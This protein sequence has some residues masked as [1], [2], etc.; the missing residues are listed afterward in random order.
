MHKNV[1][2]INLFICCVDI[3]S[4]TVIFSTVNNAYPHENTKHCFCLL[5]IQS[6]HK[7]SAVSY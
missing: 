7:T 6:L 2:I 3:S 4:P 5:H 1:E